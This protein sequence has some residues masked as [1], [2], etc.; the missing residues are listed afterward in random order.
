MPAAGD[1]VLAA[2]LEAFHALVFVLVVKRR[3]LN[4]AI[5]QRRE[6][7]AHVPLVVDAAGQRLA[8]RA[9][10]ANTAVTLA[11]LA[12]RARPDE[13]AVALARSLGVAAADADRPGD[14][15]AGF[16]ASGFAAISRAP[17]SCHR[18]AT[19]LLPNR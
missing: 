15:V 6:H 14:L 11:D 5:R 7:A 13:V 1:I 8:K 18:I 19:E 16:A 4:A 12:D 3:G 9:G 2:V 17:F 10:A